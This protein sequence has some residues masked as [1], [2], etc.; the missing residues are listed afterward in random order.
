MS[1]LVHI[2]TLRDILLTV[3]VHAIKLKSH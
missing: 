1:T 2:I 3:K